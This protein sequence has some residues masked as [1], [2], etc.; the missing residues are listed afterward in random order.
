MRH[1]RTPGPS[2]INLNAASFAAV[3]MLLKLFETATQ[4]REPSLDEDAE[5]FLDRAERD[6]LVQK[7]VERTMVGFLDIAEAACA[8]MFLALST[9]RDL[10][11]SAM[12]PHERE[13]VMRSIEV[14]AVAIVAVRMFTRRLV[15]EATTRCNE[16]C[17]RVVL[18]L[19]AALVEIGGVYD[20]TLVALRAELTAAGGMVN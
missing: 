15:Q 7:R 11:S 20:E 2:T 17:A 4:G 8:S 9:A 10:A 14:T 19:D 6:A 13:T 3:P 1:H 16:A 12:T 18:A 5:A